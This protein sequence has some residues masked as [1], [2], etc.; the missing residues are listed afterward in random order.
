MC[1]RCAALNVQIQEL[2]PQM[3]NLSTHIGT[4]H[5]EH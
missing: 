1:H 4:D 5:D 2:Y 3:P